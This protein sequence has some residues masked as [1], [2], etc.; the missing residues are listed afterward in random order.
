MKAKLKKDWSQ[1]LKLRINDLIS[2]KTVGPLVAEVA[3]SYGCNHRCI[4]CGF[5]QYQEYSGGPHYLS[6]RAFR[7]FADDFSTLGGVEIWFAGNGEPFLNPDLPEMIQYGASKGLSMAFSSNAVLVN[8]KIIEDITP[9]LT[10]AKF[11]VNGATPDDYSR[12]HQCS[13]N[14]F[15]KMK[16]NLKRFTSY[17][18]RVPEGPQ[19]IIQF[20]VMA[21]NWDNIKNMVDVHH[22]VGT[23]QL[24]FRN[25]ITK[26][27]APVPPIPDHVRKELKE[28]ELFEDV[29]VDW[30][31]F[32]KRPSSPW[33]KCYGINF[34]IN[35]TDRG[36]LYTCCRNLVLPSI[37]GNITN[38]RFIDIWNSSQK[39]KMFQDVYN[40]K[41]RKYC[42][43]WCQCARDNR[44]I[45]QI[46]KQGRQK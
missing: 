26:D 45:D 34:R 29:A 17:R 3:P 9:H 39:T 24:I 27:P 22:E 2:G 42:E 5:Q 30:N 36:E 1:E 40:Y 11:S 15:Q 6:L 28:V 41:D 4:H 37:Y 14:S 19:L 25:I 43:M 21:E 13:T 16:A 12:V 44:L 32:D 46:V 38:D 35:L 10:W 33:E 31:S 7:N 23:D 18:E 8:Q 20:L